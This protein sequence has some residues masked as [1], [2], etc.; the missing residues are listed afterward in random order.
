MI[1]NGW[2]RKRV[3]AFYATD[4]NDERIRGT[5]VAYSHSPMVLIEAEDGSRDWWGVE[6]VEELEDSITYHH[7]ESLKADVFGRG[8]AAFVATPRPQTLLPDPM[9]TGV[10][11]CKDVS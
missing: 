11:Y 1:G 2:L 6:L 3:R 5:V 7:V 9:P 4:V 8:S 10:P